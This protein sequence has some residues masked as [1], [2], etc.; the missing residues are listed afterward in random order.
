MPPLRRELSS[1][2][3]KQPIGSAGPSGVCPGEAGRMDAT[4]REPGFP[5]PE[6][7]VDL[8][9]NTWLWCHCA[10]LLASQ[11]FGAHW[12]KTGVGHVHRLSSR[13]SSHFSASGRTGSRR[14]AKNSWRLRRSTKRI[15]DIGSFCISPYWPNCETLYTHR[16]VPRCALC[17]D[18][19][20]VGPRASN[21]REKHA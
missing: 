19:F 18:Q 3:K 17:V 13:F 14:P 16:A 1:D 12:A 8:E 21:L 7:P 6:R 5:V 20:K 10:K 11:A 15:E 2:A 4:V 9:Y